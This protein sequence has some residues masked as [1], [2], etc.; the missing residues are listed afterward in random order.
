MGLFSKIFKTKSKVIDPKAIITN[1]NSSFHVEKVS[2]SFIEE[3]LKLIRN[4][5]SKKLGYPPY[6]FYTNKEL[7]QLILYKPKTKEAFMKIKG[8]GERKFN[9]FG[10]DILALFQKHEF[11]VNKETFNETK[12]VESVPKEV[13]NYD[14]ALFYVIKESRNQLAKEMKIAPFMIMSNQMIIDVCIKK[15]THTSE[16]YTIKGF[17]EERI[18]KYGEWLINLISPKQFVKKHILDYTL[19]ED[20]MERFITHFFDVFTSASFV[21]KNTLNHLIET[22]Q[23]QLNIIKNSEHVDQLNTEFMHQLAYIQ[24]FILDL[25]ASRKAR[26]DAFML[27]TIEKEASYLD[28][29]L[30]DIDPNIQLDM[31][32]RLS[33]VNDEDYALILAGAGAGKTTTVSAKVKYLIDKRQIDPSKILV[34][35]FTN[36]AVDELKERIQQKLKLPVHISTFHKLGF[37]IVKDAK[38]DERPG[39]STEGLKYKLINDY[40][41]NKIAHKPEALK[42]LVLFFGYYLDMPTPNLTLDKFMLYQQ[43]QDFTSLK[44]EIEEINNQIISKNQKIKKTIKQEV[45]RSVEEVQIANYLYLNNIDYEYEAAYP[46]HIEGSTKLYTPDFTIKNNGKIIYLEHFGIHENGT[47]SRYS[48]EELNKYHQSIQDKIQLH[49]KHQTKLIYTYSTY[50]DDQPLIKHLESLLIEHGVVIHSKSPKEVFDQIVKEESNKYFTKFTF[51]MMNFISNF[52]RNGFK[53]QDFDALYQAVTNVRARMFLNI[54]KPIYLHYQSYLS[55]HNYM[56]FED[57]INLSTQ[58]IGDSSPQNL[59]YDY[60]YII[61]DEYQDISRQR[62]N[63]TKV[64]GEK[65]R[66][67]IIAVGDDWQSIYAFAGSQVSLFTKFREEMGH[68]DYLTIDYTYRNAQQVIDVAGDFIQKNQNQL[69]KQLKS[70]KSIQKP[71]LLYEFNDQ[72]KD[73]KRGKK[74]V[75]I[76]KAIKLDEVI[77]KIVQVEGQEAEILLLV[78]YNF[79]ADQ[80]ALFSSL[81]YMTK[82]QV[83]KSVNYPK[84]KLTIL[85]IHKSKGLGFDNVILLNGSDE[86]FGFPSQI[87]IDPL[88]TMVIHDDKSYDYAEERRLFY[89]A[90]TRTKN[91][92]FILYPKSK[93]SLFVREM[94]RDYED[95][96]L[97]GSI[98]TKEEERKQTKCLICGYPLQLKNNKAYGLKLYMCTNEVELCGFMTNNLK[99]GKTSIQKCNQ[100]VGGYLIV[101]QKRSTDGVILGCTNYKDNKTGCNNTIEIKVMP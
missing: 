22:Y 40:L 94:V 101:K 18:H 24:P 53:E 48:K 41:T 11:S 2:E 12:K 23:E 76:E 96:T 82:S 42:D 30:K 38:E 78:R 87:E 100:C 99:G 31:N 92:V 9:T 43:K 73:A 90:L 83:F 98:V 64:L 5:Y 45:M 84:T 7:E 55:E 52:K 89:V 65:T 69:K 71:F 36:K 47:H 32:Q 66:A 51:L 61:V 63:L 75:V 67:K 86:Y 28:N 54:C 77:G 74:G 72:L 50:N 14:Q 17:A 49:Q 33:V 29:I 58:L 39:I 35:S 44:E 80:L 93:P 21:S 56:D 68:A 60:E 46:Y 6:Y 26:N 19:I 15:P 59:M 10:H 95:V 25:E 81:F 62:F 8:F 57:M 79:E 34:I 16:L 1:E 20:A 3:K 91:R 27:Y 70:P 85:T 4:Q 88:L 37:D 97:R 13:I